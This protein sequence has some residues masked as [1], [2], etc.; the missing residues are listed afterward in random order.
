MANMAIF[1]VGK[2]QCQ[3]FNEGMTR[4][5]KA[6]LM[7]KARERNLTAPAWKQGR[8]IWFGEGPGKVGDG[9]SL[10]RGRFVAKKQGLFNGWLAMV[11]I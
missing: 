3:V 10:D 7:A 4:Q 1:L 8:S 6:L 2:S 11:G 5:Q 9:M